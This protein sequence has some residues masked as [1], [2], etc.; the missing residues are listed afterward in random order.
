MKK[1]TTTIFAIAFSLGV[2]AQQNDTMFIH[3]EQTIFHVATSDVDS[4]VF[5]PT[6]TSV[7]MGSTAIVRDTIEITIRDTTEITIRDTIEL[8]IR[9]T[10][11][12]YDPSILASWPTSLGA[13]SFATDSTWIVS[14]GTITQI[15]SD[16]VQTDFCSNKT[17]F[18]GS[19]PLISGPLGNE[20]DCRS[21][22]GQKGDLFSGR[23]VYE[24]GNQLC[25]GPWRVPTRHD[26][27]NLSIIFGT[28]GFGNQNNPTIRDKYI[29]DW[30]GTFG[31]MTSQ[32]NTLSDQDTRGFYWSQT[33]IDYYGIGLPVVPTRLYSIEISSSNFR[34]LTDE[35]LNRGFS[36]RC[37]RTIY[38]VD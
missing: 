9:D 21:N 28:N 23:A 15:W 8:T 10:V 38:D 35:F 6:G 29:N 30:G 25:P 7:P 22:P 32:T 12:L 37:V 11:D 24:F 18:R 16:A 3:T 19:N 34:P 4:I 5:S 2:F 14:N 1:I 33:G 20:I 17:T 27:V 31:G 26:F 36:L 13:A